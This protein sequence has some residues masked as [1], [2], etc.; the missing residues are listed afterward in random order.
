MRAIHLQL[1]G[2][3]ASF[4]LRPGTT[5]LDALRDQLAITT[6]KRGCQPEGSCGCCACG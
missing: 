3:P 1:N 4:E 5:A 6:P 2:Q